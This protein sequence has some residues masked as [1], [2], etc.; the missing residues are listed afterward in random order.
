MASALAHGACRADISVRCYRLP[1][2]I[3]K[4]TKA[5]AL[6]KRRAF[7]AQLA[8]A[9]LLVIDDFGL[10]PMTEPVVHDLLE[11]LEDRYDWQSISITSQIPIT[12]WHAHLRDKT[13][14][15]AI[16]DRLV[17]NAQ[18]LPSKASPCV[19]KKA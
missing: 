2:L 10:T 5:S 13:V 6:Y 14:A 15:D 9:Q 3:D 18:R 1:R 7:L 4:S 19:N 17:L 8:K 16:I 11:I 12:Q